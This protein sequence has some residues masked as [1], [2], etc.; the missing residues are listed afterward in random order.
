MTVAQ[1]EHRI[2][3]VKPQLTLRRHEAVS[4]KGARFYI[5][6]AAPSGSGRHSDLGTL[7]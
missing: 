1:I 2:E 4:R 5:W 7:G 6:A 3:Q